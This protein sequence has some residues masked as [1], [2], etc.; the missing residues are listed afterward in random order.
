MIRDGTDEV[1]ELISSTMLKSLLEGSDSSS[2]SDCDSPVDAGD[3]E[4]EE[5][6]GIT[7]RFLGLHLSLFGILAIQLNLFLVVSEKRLFY[8]LITFEGVVCSTNRDH[9]FM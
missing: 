5:E 8:P 1:L 3:D 9:A 2:D 7:R 6:I 4:D